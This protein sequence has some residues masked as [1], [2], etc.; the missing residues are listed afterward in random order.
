MAPPVSQELRE[1][2]IA[3]R[4]ELHLPINAIINL[5]GRCEKTV[6]NVLN[7]FRDYNQAT[8]PFTQP[9]GRKR[10]LDRNDLN[11]IESILSAEP[12]LFLDEIQEKL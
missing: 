9:R 3:W 8:N 1:R 11:Y 7:T 12:G 6:H 5:S 2:I 10:I 4:F